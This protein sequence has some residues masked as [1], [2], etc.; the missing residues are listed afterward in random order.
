M[1]DSA[2]DATEDD[3]PKSDPKTDKLF[4][5]FLSEVSQ[6]LPFMLITYL[7][8]LYPNILVHHVNTSCFCALRS[9]Q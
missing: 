3:K 8:A 4:N 5:K 1:A 2:S 7:S 6:Y 9:K